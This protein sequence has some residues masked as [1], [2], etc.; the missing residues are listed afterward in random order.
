[1]RHLYHCQL[2]WADQDLLGHVNNVLYA[3]YL[4]EARVDLLRT[5]APSTRSADPA[6][7][8]I[9]VRHEVSYQ[10]S[11]HFGFAPVAVECW[12]S[13]IRA[14]S[15]TVDYEIFSLT[16]A[17]ERD[18]HVRARSVLAPFDFTSQRPRR[19]DADERAA[20]ST[21]LEPGETLEALPADPLVAMPGTDYE[22]AVRFSDVDGYNHVNNVKY[23]EYFQ[24]SR[25]KLMRELGAGLHARGL[26]LV[27]ARTRIDYLGQA[28]YR[29]EPYACP[30]WVSRVGRTSMV[31]DSL[32]LDGDRVLARGQVVGVAVSAETGRP[33]EIPSNYREALGEILGPERVTPAS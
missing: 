31:Y 26:H 5:H 9:V 22:V 33:V 20:L 13:E 18:V 11:L 3:D 27:V 16:D 12:I 17:G 28:T 21:L 15:F 4:Q 30:S 23:F 24:E 7:G 32:M 29:S 8:I 10:S 2:R 6:T 19:L 25:I 14:A 1:M